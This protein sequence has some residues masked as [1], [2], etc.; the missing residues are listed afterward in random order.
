MR[1]SQLEICLD[2]L[3]AVARG[4]RKPSC[5]MRYANLSWKR[6]RKYLGFLVNGGL[7]VNDGDGYMLTPRGKMAVE[8]Y[9]H[10]LMAMRGVHLFKDEDIADVVLEKRV[11][12]LEE[13]VRELERLL[14]L[15]GEKNIHEE[16]ETE[17]EF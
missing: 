7:L 3:R 8:H 1:R 9:F 13:R 4:K 16:W 12:M 15:S 5:I 2:I 17:Y 10:V 6:L 14:R 11:K